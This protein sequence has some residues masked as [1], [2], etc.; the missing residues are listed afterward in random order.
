MAYYHESHGHGI[1]GVGFV[2]TQN[3]P[4]VFIDLDQCIEPNTGAV[5]A[6]AR[7]VLK[8]IPSY[9]GISP[10]GLGLHIPHP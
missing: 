4:F 10:S 1:K 7:G 3:D 2:L 6:W 9:T 5:Q 8:Q